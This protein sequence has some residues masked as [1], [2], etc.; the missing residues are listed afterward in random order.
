MSIESQNMATTFALMPKEKYYEEHPDWYNTDGSDMCY[1]NEAMQTQMIEN[2]KGYILKNPEFDKV[3]VGQ[4]DNCSWCNCEKCRGIIS[5]YN[6]ANVSTAVLCINRIEKEINEWLLSIGDGR[7]MHFGVFAY[8]K[9]INAPA[10]KE[11]GKW[12]ALLKCNP[13]VFIMYAPIEADYFYSFDDAENEEFADIIEAWNACAE[14]IY[15][16]SYAANFNWYLIDF[17]NW[18][19]LQ[20]TFQAFRRWGVQLNFSQSP[21]DMAGMPNAPTFANLRAYLISN[22]SF[23]CDADYQTLIDDF[24]KHYYKDASA[25]IYQYFTELRDLEVYNVQVNGM[26]GFCGSNLKNEI[27]WPKGTLLRWEGYIQKAYEVIDYL[28][29]E[30]AELYETLYWRINKESIMIRYLLLD[31]HSYLYDSVE[32]QNLRIQ[33]MNDMNHLGIYNYKENTSASELYTS[34]GIL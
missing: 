8:Q 18:E 30:N 4:E 27:Y 21:Y 31:M 24:F 33:F 26:S 17:P 12:K 7:T 14:T 9:S 11:N 20:S 32:L 19:N 23:D 28:K 6:N 3:M 29:E 25:Y 15:V 10:V 34:W 22:L 16:W 5:Q 2:L 13:N 1:S